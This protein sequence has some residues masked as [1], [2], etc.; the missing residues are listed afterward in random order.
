M[1][2]DSR[3][4]FIIA[5]I[6]NHFGYPVTDG[7]VSHI[8]SSKELDAL[9]DDSNC[10][11]LATKPEMTQGVRLIQVSVMNTTHTVLTNALPIYRSTTPLRVRQL[12]LGTTGWCSSNYSQ[13]SSLQTIFIPI[14]SSHLF[15]THPSTHSITLYRKCL[16]QCCSKEQA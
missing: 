16:P 5:T 4:E 6:G 15:L 10:H 2:E 12:L 9:L 11:V 3:K 1:A 7:A 14:S 13:V 8:M